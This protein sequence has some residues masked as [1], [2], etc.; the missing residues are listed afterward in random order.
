MF[1]GLRRLGSGRMRLVAAPAIARMREPRRAGR[2]S[3]GVVA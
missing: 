2:I 3:E 1:H